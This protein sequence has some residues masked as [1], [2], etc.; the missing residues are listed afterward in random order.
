MGTQDFIQFYHRRLNLIWD[1]TRD[2]H[3]SE[4]FESSHGTPGIAKTLMFHMRAF[5]DPL[6]RP[7]VWNHIDVYPEF[8]VWGWDIRTDRKGPG[9]AILGHVSASGF[10]WSVREWLPSGPILAGVKVRITTAPLYRPGEEIVLNVVRLRDGEA[11]GQRHKADQEGRLSLE[12]DGDEYEVGIGPQPVLTVAG[13]TIEDAPWAADTVPVRLRVRFLNKGDRASAAARLRWETPNPGVRL[14]DGD[15]VVPPLE[16]GKTAEVPLGFTVLDDT[17]EIVK[18]FAVDG[19]ARLP[20]EIPTFPPAAKAAD[21]RLADGIALPVYQRAVTVEKLTLGTGNADGQANPGE[22]VAV[23]L[24]DGGAYRAA[25]LFTNDPCVDL[26][27]R[28]SDVWGTYDDVG[29]SV[30][31]S[32]P[33]IRPGCA[34]GHRIRALARVQLPDKP[35]HKIRYAA[36]EFQVR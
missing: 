15:A 27:T 8:S 33:L 19:R 18:L 34:P 7:E 13:C 11:R 22:R 24:R 28:V 32:L 31:Y 1:Y 4:V 12:L 36:V 21:F 17:R 23:L 16:P 29:A 20:L 6:A 35:N 9:F 2:H 5:A 10:R 25:E 26:A 14:E 30:K 3:E